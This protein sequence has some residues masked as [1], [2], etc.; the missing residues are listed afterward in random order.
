MAKSGLLLLLLSYAPIS[1][2]QA[3]T[4]DGVPVGF[5]EDG[6]PYIGRADAPV[7]RK[8]MD[9]VEFLSDN[10]GG[11]TVRMVIHLEK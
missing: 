11:N 4:H 2:G 6:Y 3:A 7:N 8:L 10:M 1:A 5:T 9:E